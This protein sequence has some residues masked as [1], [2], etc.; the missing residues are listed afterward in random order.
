MLVAIIR[1][2]TVNTRKSCCL[3]LWYPILC[4]NKLAK[5]SSMDKLTR[6]N[7][8][9]QHC[10]DRRFPI[11]NN[12][13]TRSLSFFLWLSETG[14][15]QEPLYVRLRGITWFFEIKRGSRVS[16]KNLT[17]RHDVF[18]LTNLNDCVMGFVLLSLP[19]CP[20]VSL[21]WIMI[22]A[23]SFVGCSNNIITWMT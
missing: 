18:Q 15:L 1:T 11:G 21:P 23:R 22:P 14:Q 19:T 2:T 9:Q 3:W 17:W 20:S 6:M 4:G 10:I 8:R 7:M 16:Y 5:S 13:N 12:P